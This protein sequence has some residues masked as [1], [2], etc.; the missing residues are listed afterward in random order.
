MALILESGNFFRGSNAEFENVLANLPDYAGGAWEPSNNQFA[1]S[2][3]WKIPGPPKA[4]K[5]NWFKSDKV[6][7]DG[8][9]KDDLRNSC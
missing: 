6:T 9:K 8:P 1:R 2:H 4:T 7:F 5:I 3:L